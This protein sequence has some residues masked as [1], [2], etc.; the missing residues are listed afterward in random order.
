MKYKFGTN[1]KIFKILLLIS[2]VFIVLGF[3]SMTQ[4]GIGSTPEEEAQTKAHEKSDMDAQMEV[5]KCK[6]IEVP[7]CDMFDCTEAVRAIT[8]LKKCME[9]SEK[10]NTEI[11]NEQA[12]KRLKSEVDR[13]ELKIRKREAIAGAF[14]S[15]LSIF[16]K[17]LARDTATWIASGGKGQKPLFITEGWGAY[18]QDTADKALG[19]F[20]DQIGQ[21][22]GQDLCRPSLNV[23]LVIE[24][25]IKDGGRVPQV[26][27]SFSTMMTN[28]N[29]AV[30]RADF[31]IQYTNSFQA[32]E[33]DISTYL[34]LGDK[35]LTYVN[36]KIKAAEDEAAA[37]N[38]FKDLKDLAGKVLTPGTTVREMLHVSPNVD[39]G[40][41]QKKDSIWT[42]TKWD[43][44]ETFINTLMSQLLKNL[45][46]GLFSDKGN[47]SGG[48]GFALPDLSGLL[49]PL[50][51]PYSEGATQAEQRF[52]KL[53]D[54]TFKEVGAFD[55]LTKLSQCSDENQSNPAATECVIDQKLL[56]AI[57]DKKQLYQILDGS[58]GSSGNLGIGSRLFAPALG[59]TGNLEN[60][61]PL[62]SII[63]LRKYRI[64]PVGWEIAARIANSEQKN[65]TLK[66]IAGKY[67]DPSD[68]DKRFKGLVDP[69]WTLKVP[70]VY[71]R[72]QGYGGHNTMR[73]S[74]SGA[75]NR[76]DY[77]A[78]EQQCLQQDIDGNCQSYGY[79]TEE[80]KIWTFDKACE[81]K[82]NTCQSFADSSGKNQSYLMDT[83]DFRNCTSQNA[84][85]RW[86]S[87]LLDPINNIWR[88][89]A[90]NIITKLTNTDNPLT[91][92][93]SSV[94]KWH[95]ISTDG[96][97]KMAQPCSSG[98]CDGTAATN[99]LYN[100]ST[101]K[102]TFIG[103]NC[104]TTPGSSGCFVE[105]CLDSNNIF[106]SKNGNME[107]A[108]AH[109]WIPADWNF[110]NAS[111][112]NINRFYRVANEGV[113]KSHALRIIANNAP[114]VTEDS[115]FWIKA[116]NLKIEP[117]KN[118]QLKFQ[119]RGNYFSGGYAANGQLNSGAIVISV[120][121]G[122]EKEEFA[123]YSFSSDWN[124]F[125][126]QFNAGNYSSTTIKIS[127]K[128][129]T[130]ADVYLDDFELKKVKEDC[131][132]NSIWINNATDTSSTLAT[133]NEI[134]LTK[135]AQ[136]CTSVDEGCSQFIRLKEN[137]G[138]NLIPNNAGFENG[139]D[140][141]TTSAG[142]TFE[143]SSFRSHS[144]TY[145][146][147]MVGTD[148]NLAQ[149]LAIGKDAK[150]LTILEKGK[151]YILSAWV[152]SINNAGDAYRISILDGDSVIASSTSY[153]TDSDVNNW[154]LISVPF[155]SYISLIN[156]KV[157]ISISSA[158]GISKEVYFDD[159]KLEEVRY[160]VKDPTSYSPLVPSQMPY[161]QL[162]Y[163]KKA[164]DY[165][166]CYR[167][168]DGIWAT[169][170]NLTNILSNQ[171]GSC[172]KFAPV[173]TADE[174]GCDIYKPTNGDPNVPGV[175]ETAD[176]CP[177]ECS[178]Y[179][180]Y[181]QEKT[182][183]VSSKFVQFIANKT[184]KYCS[185]SLAGCDEFTNLDE[186]GRGAEQKTN[187]VH[188]KACQK[189]SIDDGAYYT[190]EGQETTG[191]QLRLYK[192]KKT[193]TSTGA[194]CTNLTY[195]T[196][197]GATGQGVCHDELDNSG[198]CTKEDMASNPDCRQF[199]DAGGNITYRLL[200]KTISVSDNCHPYR[201]TKKELGNDSAYKNCV[202]SH[203]WWSNGNECVYMA[204]PSE[205]LTCS[206]GAV[207]CRAYT[208]NYGNNIR[209]VFSVSDFAN[210][211]LQ[212]WLDNLK[213]ASAVTTSPESTYQGGIS[214]TNLG[215]NTIQKNVLIYQNKTYMLSFWAKS[216]GNNFKFESIKFSGASSPTDNFSIPSTKD[217]DLAQARIDVTNEWKYYEV[218]PVFVTW[219]PATDGEYLQFNLPS[220]QKVFLDNILL[221][222]V[223]DSVY[224]VENS[225]FTPIS[226][227]NDIND[228][229]GQDAYT[230]SIGVASPT[231]IC[232][233][234]STNSQ[235][236]RCVPGQMLGCKAYTTNN[237]QLA[238]LKSF[239]R[240]C[241]SEAA[242]CEKLLYTSNYDN[243]QGGI[244]NDPAVGDSEEDKIIVP[245]YE[246]VYL[247]NNS[248]YSCKAENKGC[249]ALGLPNLN[250]FDEVIGYSTMY[251]KNNPDRYAT[252]LC[253][254]NEVWCDQFAGSNSLFYF[255]NPRNKLCEFRSGAGVEAGW[256]IQG[257]DEI[258]QV[259]PDQTFGTG[260]EALRNK[261]QPIGPYSNI[262]GA[263]TSTDTLFNKATYSGWVGTCPS[264]KSGC[265]EYVDPIRDIYPNLNYKSED[266][267]SLDPNYLYS[268]NK[269]D[270]IQPGD[271][272]PCKIFYPLGTTSNTFY[273][274]A[275][276]YSD[277]NCNISLLDSS[278][279]VTRA[280]VYYA[281]N[282]ETDR[283]SCG[284]VA[285]YKTGCVLFNE[286]S[287]MN[288]SYTTNSPSALLTERNKY[289]NFSSQNTY[290]NYILQRQ[291][292]IKPNTEN[293]KDSNVLLKVLPDRTCKDWLYCTMYQK[294]DDA[295]NNKNS[296]FQNSDTCL[297]FDVCE[298]MDY[299]TGMC[300][301]FPE[302]EKA[303]ISTSSSNFNYLT[304]Y[305]VPGYLPMDK[306][307]EIGQTASLVNG[308]FESVYADS[309]DL[310]VGWTLADNERAG[311]WSKDKFMAGSAPKDREEGASYL[312]LYSDHR[313]M[314][315]IISVDRESGQD[316]IISG[317][318]NT[319]DVHPTTT[320]A[321]ILV[322]EL[323]GN[324][325]PL[326]SDCTVDI[327]SSI[328]LNINGNASPYWTSY[329]RLRLESGRPWTHVTLEIPAGSLNPGTKRLRI[330][331]VNYSDRKESDGSTTCGLEW[332]KFT[333]KDCNV[334]GYSL[335]DDMEIKPVLN[336]YGTGR[337]Y[338]NR[339]CRLFPDQSSLSCKYQKDNRLF[340]GWFGY[341]IS[342]DPK[343][344]DVCLQWW[345]VDQ[346]QGETVDEV[347]EYT[348]TR[349]LY[350]CLS[351]DIEG[352]MQYG[353]V[354][355]DLGDIIGS[356]IN[357][358]TLTM[359]QAKTYPLPTDRVVM[360]ACVVG[361]EGGSSAGSLSK[362]TYTTISGK[363]YGG[364]VAIHIPIP[365]TPLYV[366]IS[367]AFYNKMSA[368]EIIK[369]S[370]DALINGLFGGIMD[371]FSSFLPEG[372][373][374]TNPLQT[375][376]EN[377][378]IAEGSTDT[379]GS[380]MAQ[381][382]GKLA[383]LIGICGLDEPIK[384]I[385]WGCLA[386]DGGNMMC[387]SV[388]LSVSYY[389]FDH[390]T[391]PCKDMIMTVNSDGVNKGLATRI[392]DIGRGNAYRLLVDKDYFAAEKKDPGYYQYL[393]V[394]KPFGSFLS[395]PGA[396]EDWDGSGRG[397]RQ[398]LELSEFDFP[399]RVMPSYFGTSYNFKD[400]IDESIK[401]LVGQCSVSRNICMN[402]T[403][404]ENWRVPACPL[405][406]EKCKLLS[407]VG[408]DLPPSSGDSKSSIQAIKNIFAESFNS[409]VWET[410][411]DG[412]G[413]YEETITP[414]D[415]E[416]RIWTLPQVQCINNSRTANET[417]ASTPP[418]NNLS[419]GYCYVLPGIDKNK[420]KI[421][422][423]LVDDSTLVTSNSSVRLTF[424]A[425]VD[426]DQ[427]PIKSYAVEWGDGKT[428]SISGVSLRS[429]AN[430][431]YPFALYHI[432]DYAKLENFPSASC[433]YVT[434]ECTA[435]IKIYLRDNWEK[436]VTTSFKI[437]IKP[438]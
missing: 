154:K 350:Q 11:I 240:L 126:W 76:S 129:G 148:C 285:D 270:K 159:L 353:S 250:R 191:Y 212:G 435:E 281:I 260:Y 36:D 418:I 243:Y 199:Y 106:S 298:K 344:P 155:S 324:N 255:K 390:V 411:A 99:C 178:G 2:L 437:K 307:D 414:T 328:T 296:T 179:Q 186:V 97:V 37:N 360:G 112:D 413:Y 310:P 246:P 175:A 184:P 211:D 406:E 315:E 253:K 185:A 287:S 352:Q 386:P 323:N 210:N 134:Y 329:S 359:G 30:K 176:I 64:V 218:G 295:S 404:L 54:Y 409:W 304:G 48:G 351:A 164:P 342:R 94:L 150:D 182:E 187:F 302:T 108:T 309:S 131:G 338:L 123:P 244:F 38:G 194:P 81:P 337:D 16:S 266:K 132:N 183:F 114:V 326:P 89:Q 436:T 382:A 158:D 172:A 375:F 13:D 82:Y 368:I 412:Y 68:L 116:D 28:W 361:V 258:C 49:N 167:G 330:M 241:R 205:S 209:N 174:V 268:T 121:R 15:S 189:P 347:N 117:N 318:I 399:N 14:K 422:D 6:E 232:V 34:L 146:L 377:Q 32:G 346:I 124:D 201:R 53:Q 271:I 219:S 429:R 4:A 251:V 297:G 433:D 193:N 110:D 374:G 125:T 396:P 262:T 142:C 111:F 80:R 383:C 321:E 86:Y 387:E 27:C 242:G 345:P 424:N 78:D 31:S 322:Q 379:V 93:N 92:V 394:A 286:R 356:D 362:V 265:T 213:T 239:A 367:C 343:N 289:L 257:T 50:A 141:W 41:A 419:F 248:K 46:S 273:V 339:S 145:S 254:L 66:D 160:N 416:N 365:E 8:N 410:D 7:I 192:L 280:G 18:L 407:D 235:T 223:R 197:T 42:A 427:L 162:A 188:I 39:P 325:T 269:I 161:Q 314:S 105:Q 63:I 245:A 214:L 354:D 282:S 294:K 252:D 65:Y 190:W 20:L 402:P 369:N 363:K 122:E 292:P 23:R 157:S 152:N 373:E 43:F 70:D 380:T 168:P 25:S 74:Q 279:V 423:K 272:R 222:E 85:C 72:R 149:T 217:G 55:V 277:V 5:A 104:T 226:C 75:I 200:S 109:D 306:M 120:I 358:G 51:S 405:P 12:W 305:S 401:R 366:D 331:L 264:T 71:C 299:D 430:L 229:Q 173:C 62:R 276:L 236:H 261:L 33:N 293:P 391:V 1:L 101:E 98:A 313:A 233:D 398:P 165:L 202:D 320:R 127:V 385:S 195:P 415:G 169:S 56:S 100:S 215:T 35:K 57:K 156:P 400:K 198:I 392:S 77:C 231:G 421:N 24:A 378:P 207:G 19:D 263:I 204:N 333:E 357:S 45:Q 177:S 58:G 166:N 95:Q 73:D 118:Y 203:G 151:K 87:M 438:Q 372:E 90:P 60:E 425:F 139:L 113:N 275:P 147:K 388:P 40:E 355:V 84:G 340:Y 228:S 61:I 417:V 397:G 208:G 284:G 221:K 130:T 79:C 52:S 332:N 428:T 47:D 44:I 88:H 312:Q 308:N 17:T 128:A 249:M 319:L 91:A 220:G 389:Y 163:L 227:D 206:A 69:Y 431:D 181:K 301:Y 3:S 225:W 9:E 278:T 274:K 434:N 283:S 291:E 10:Q 256:Y 119:A 171:S 371:I 317:W 115:S 348:G 393:T 136:T 237:N 216:N 247:V 364:A 341:C 288:Y 224:L 259:T 238:Y 335:F 137:L 26:R 316:Y 180:V 196:S 96:L 290:R 408:R 267:I 22:Y 381:Q 349:P 153:Y 29:S 21:M 334:A 376:I 107:Q 234:Q 144:G 140:G 83:L 133:F 403:Y 420:I 135:Q 370:A 303:I 311:G 327:C 300:D 336:V 102:C 103:G 59:A 170:T 67:D 143:K 432:Y 395:L 230:R 384:E 426:P 138:T